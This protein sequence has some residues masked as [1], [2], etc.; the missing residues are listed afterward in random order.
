MDL[1]ASESPAPS[2]RAVERGENAS[3][4]G[5]T[6]GETGADPDRHL[7]AS[8]SGGDRDA[9]ERLLRRHYDRIHRLAWRLTGSGSEAE[10]VAQDVCCKLVEKIGTFKG[11]AKFTTWLTGIVVNTC[12]DRHR[13]GKAIAR[14]KGHL[15][16]F[17]Q[18]SPA[19]DGRDLHLRAW[20]ASA[21]SRLDPS[22]RDTIVLVA[23]ED[24][25]HAEAASALGVAESTVSWRMRQARRL[26]AA[27][28]EEEAEHGH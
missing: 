22:L 11:D 4:P 8:A 14:L 20:L 10:D 25:S 24:M 13:R 6:C 3:L 18:L 9:F 17:A 28:P 19:P 1:K 27:E 21:L 15:G 5:G 12:R 23:G 16:V 26:L 2:C 7:V